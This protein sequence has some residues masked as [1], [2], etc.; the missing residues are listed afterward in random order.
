MCSRSN[1]QSRSY[2]FVFQS[3]LRAFCSL[4]ERF[5]DVTTN[6]RRCLHAVGVDNVNS[7]ITDLEIG[8]FCSAY[9]IFF[10]FCTT[11]SHARLS[12]SAY[13]K[14][15]KSFDANG[16]ELISRAKI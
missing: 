2:M 4:F 13:I 10:S 14:Y 15:E 3:L 5:F 7:I 16:S 9:A 1:V 12:S 6:R 8:L 11:M